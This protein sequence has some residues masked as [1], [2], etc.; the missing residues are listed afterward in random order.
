MSTRGQQVFVQWDVIPMGFLQ[1]APC[2]VGQ[3]QRVLLISWFSR[4]SDDL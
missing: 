3:V 2:S 1:H 4:I